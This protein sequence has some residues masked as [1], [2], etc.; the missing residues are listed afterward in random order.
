MIYLYALSLICLSSLRVHIFWPMLVMHLCW[1]FDTHSS[2]LYNPCHLLQT[3]WFP[4]LDHLIDYG[5]PFRHQ[6]VPQS[7]LI[8]YSSLL[9]WKSYIWLHVLLWLSLRLPVIYLIHSLLK[10]LVYLSWSLLLGLIFSVQLLIISH[11]HLLTLIVTITCLLLWDW[12]WV[13]SPRVNWNLVD[14]MMRN[15]CLFHV[16]NWD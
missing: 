6:Q 10:L 13:Y 8:Y 14:Y 7:L 4:T 12:L 3:A 15:E 9:C 16:L 2:A 11:Q 5:T 1:Y